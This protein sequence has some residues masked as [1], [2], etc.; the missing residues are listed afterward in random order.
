[1]IAWDSTADE[2]RPECF[3]LPLANSRLPTGVDSKT[4]GAE[5]DNMVFC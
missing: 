4:Q 3:R 1:M 5:N 2:S